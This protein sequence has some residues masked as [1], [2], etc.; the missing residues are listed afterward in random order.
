MHTTVSYGRTVGVFRRIALMRGVALLRRAAGSRRST[1]CATSPTPLTVRCEGSSNAIGA[2]ASH[3]AIVGYPRYNH[4]TAPYTRELQ[5]H[6]SGGIIARRSRQVAGGLLRR[7]CVRCAPPSHALIVGRL[8]VAML[9]VAACYALAS[10]H[11]MQP[12]PC[13][14]QDDALHC[15]ML[16]SWQCGI[17]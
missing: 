6:G 4:T 5:S 16:Y 3:P 14:L 8:H 2:L 10:G 12:I 17:P 1:A 15:N 7:T 11:C 13:A 9:A